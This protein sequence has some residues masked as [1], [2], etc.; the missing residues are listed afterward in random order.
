METIIIEYIGTVVCMATI[1]FLLYLC[2]DNSKDW[3]GIIFTII[4]IGI[5][6]V[7]FL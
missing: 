1:T 3:S 4:I 6:S 2:S 7:F 5:I